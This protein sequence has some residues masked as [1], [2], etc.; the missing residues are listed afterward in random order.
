M[1]TFYGILE[2]VTGPSSPQNEACR[3]RCIPLSPRTWL[4]GEKAKYFRVSSQSPQVLFFRLPETV[5]G[6]RQAAFSC[7]SRRCGPGRVASQSTGGWAGLVAGSRGGD[8]GST[9]MS[10]PQ[11]GKLQGWAPL[12]LQGGVRVLDFLRGCSGRS[13]RG[14]S[15]RVEA[16]GSVRPGCCSASGSICGACVQGAQI[17]TS[18]LGARKA[19]KNLQQFLQVRFPVIQFTESDR[20]SPLL[21]YSCICFDKHA[22]HNHN[23]DETDDLC[24][25]QAPAVLPSVLPKGY[26]FRV[27]FFLFFYL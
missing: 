2:S 10:G 7:M 21:V 6:L 3:E 23:H 11:Q 19:P 12:G 15:W 22:T 26:I 25:P 17:Q 24:H 18:P 8:H 16:S 14:W 27:Y 4:L 20:N 9:H 1:R 13:Q 5:G